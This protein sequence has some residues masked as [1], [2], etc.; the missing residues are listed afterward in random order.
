MKKYDFH[1]L[2]I[3][4][5]DVKNRPLSEFKELFKK[6]VDDGGDVNVYLNDEPLLIKSIRTEN[7]DVADFLLSKNANVNQT[8]RDDY[9]AL[10]MLIAKRDEFLQKLFNKILSK[11]DLTHKNFVGKTALVLAAF[12]IA[13]LWMLEKLIEKNI[14]WEIEDNFN[15]DFLYYLNE[16]RYEYIINKYPEKYNLYIALK[17]AANFNI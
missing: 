9:N 15:N 13:P 3:K 11:T 2:K 10:M 5:F 7:F 17:K 6:F 16:S 14:S 8:D 12:A 4:L 1:S